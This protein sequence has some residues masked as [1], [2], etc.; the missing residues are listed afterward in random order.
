MGMSRNLKT[1]NVGIVGVN[2]L[3]ILLE[4]L[5]LESA[6]GL[7]ELLRTG[8][9]ETVLS[10]PY[11]LQD[12]VDGKCLGPMGFA[13]CGDT[14]VWLI[15]RKK[16]GGE[17]GVKSLWSLLWRRLRNMEDEIE[18]KYALEMVHSDASNGINSG[19][20][21]DGDCLALPSVR[22]TRKRRRNQ[23][24]GVTGNFEERPTLT[25]AS[26]K[27]PEVWNW[28]MNGNG[29]LSLEDHHQE[30]G[31]GS[32]LLQG[33]ISHTVDTYEND[34]NRGMTCVSRTGSSGAF[35]AA[36][37]EQDLYTNWQQQQQKQ[38]SS[39]T[40]KGEGQE[41]I[42]PFSLIRYRVESAVPST[43]TALASA[44]RNSQIRSG[45]PG[46]HF[47]NSI[48]HRDIKLPSHA[49]RSGGRKKKN[50]NKRNTNTKNKL[51]NAKQVKEQDRNNKN[52][53]AKKKKDRKR[54]RDPS[55]PGKMPIQP[56]LEGSKNGVWRDPVTELDFEVDLAD[57]YEKDFKGSGKNLLMGTGTYTKFVFKLRIYGIALYVDSADVLADPKL[58]ELAGLDA[59]GLRQNEEFYDHLMD[60][61][62]TKEGGQVLKTVLV[63]LNMQLST[64]TMRSSLDADWKKLNQRLKD[65]VINCSLKERDANENMLKKIKSAENPSRC[66]CGQVAPPEYQADPSCCAR[67]TTLSFT[68]HK[69]GDCEI[70]LDGRL[71]DR[72]AE[73][74]LARGI[75]YEYMRGDD[76]MSIEARDNFAKGF[77]YLLAPLAH[78]KG[79]QPLSNNGKKKANNNNISNENPPVV[80]QWL[81][82]NAQS[83]FSNVTYMAKSTWDAASKG[84]AE[85]VDRK[86]GEIWDAISSIPQ[87]AIG[88]LADRFIRHDQRRQEKG[89]FTVVPLQYFAGDCA[90]SSGDEL[91]ML[92]K[93]PT[94]QKKSFQN[95]LTRLFFFA[96][97]HL[98]LLLLVVVSVTGSYAIQTKVVV[99]KKGGEKRRVLR[100]ASSSSLTMLSDPEE[101]LNSKQMLRQRRS[102]SFLSVLNAPSNKDWSYYDI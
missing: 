74:D 47:E 33:T 42:I 20:I 92:Q 34:Q 71:M 99:L 101:A 61:P 46:Y 28:K 8:F 70:R 75:F 95:L 54:G 32:R 26:C 40:L 45:I 65:M 78:V 14:T 11:W 50:R 6:G 79:M 23:K 10:Q 68:W 18:W 25:L 98:Y 21:E 48:G 38:H 91:L 80:L 84:V 87:Q 5:D 29:V 83:F 52:V 56:Y 60:M 63:K 62:T 4:K 57:H 58:Q 13:E 49:Q 3:A 73:P 9:D 55:R 16:V 94:E 30:K 89:P 59:E 2:P 69:N 1:W 24:G 66:S 53:I 82:E 100:Y 39:T 35:V 81:Q 22:Q 36:C 41:R 72:F 12:D 19:G 76:P 17:G 27:S 90:N 88:F 64:E 15:R 7:D 102:S 37:T 51:A 97:V 44:P 67:G 77:P 31:T 86:R 96:M 85:D 43:S 93:P